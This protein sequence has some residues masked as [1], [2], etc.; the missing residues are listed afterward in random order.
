MLDIFDKQSA[1]EL[2]FDAN[3]KKWLAKRGDSLTGATVTV[4]ADVGITI[5]SQVVDVANG[6]VKV[7]FAGGTNGMKYKVTITI[8]TAGGRKKEHEYYVRIKD[9]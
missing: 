7:F 9:L 2:D 3:F 1:E 8:A 6:V 5:K 4:A